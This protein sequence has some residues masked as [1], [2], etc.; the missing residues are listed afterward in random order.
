M[1]GARRAL[2]I[3]LAAAAA[4]GAAGA[5]VES[6]D[7]AFAQ[8]QEGRPTAAEA[9]D[10]FL[11]IAPDDPKRAERLERAAACAV[12]AGRAELGLQLLAEPGAKVGELGRQWRLR[13][14]L[15]LGRAAEAAAWLSTDPF[16]SLA[17]ALRAEETAALRLGE[18]ALR[19]GD[20]DT[21]I[22]LFEAI[23]RAQP[24]DAGRLCNLALTYR[25][26]GRIADAEAA[27][28]Q[29]LQAA[30]RDHE[31]WNDWGLFLRG[32]G[33][34]DEAGAAFRRSLGVES[35]TGEGPAATNLVHME[36]LRPRAS[37]QDPLPAARAA[38]RLRPESPMLR[39]LVLD[40][41]VMRARAEPDKGVA[42][43]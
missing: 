6:F 4:G 34:W 32:T 37:L 2:G 14:L 22:A 7:R 39:R 26:V 27:Y 28:Q 23:A 20:L 10:A 13:A 31:V 24:G 38:L 29:A 18:R 3:A 30:P 11:R 21:G 41:A 16:E 12:A 42:P 15:Q 5:Q 8:W 19:S 35:R 36:I 40:L 25:H 9:L 17:D 33:R 43:R 1:N